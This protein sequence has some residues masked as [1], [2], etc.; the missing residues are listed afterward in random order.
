[1]K[2]NKYVYIFVI[3]LAFVVVLGI[4]TLNKSFNKVNFI[5]DNDIL[6]SRYSSS[7]PVKIVFSMKYFPPYEIDDSK[8]ILDFWN[9]LSKLPAYKHIPLDKDQDYDLITGYIYFLDGSKKHFEI[10]ESFSIEELSYGSSKNEEMNYI[11][12]KM[13]DLILSAEN[14]SKELL[15]EENKVIGFKNENDYFIINHY[16]LIELANLLKSST[17]I[18]STDE[19]GKVIQGNPN[20]PYLISVLRDENQFLTINVYNEDYFSIYYINNF[21]YL[22]KGDILSYLKIT[23]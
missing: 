6:M 13:K 16:N 20:P 4:Y 14:L 5:Q 18:T 19:I 23:Y 11:K 12:S 10:S 3:S 22:L 7:T 9:R 2:I 17:I 8:I 15:N 1:M 21:L